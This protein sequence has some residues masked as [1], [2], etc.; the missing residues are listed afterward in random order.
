[1][2]LPRMTTRLWMVVVAA[3]EALFTVIYWICCNLELWG[4]IVLGSMFLSLMAPT[5]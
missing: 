3:V 4:Y 2:R 1:M 5:S